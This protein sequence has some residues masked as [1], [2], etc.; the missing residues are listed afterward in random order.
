MQCRPS[1]RRGSGGSMYTRKTHATR[2]APSRGRAHDQPTTREGWV[3][4]GGV[5][6]GLVLLWKS[7]NADGGKEPWFKANAGSNKEP[8][9]GQPYQTRA[10]SDVAKCM[11]CGTEGRTGTL[12]SRNPPAGDGRIG[13]LRGGPRHLGAGYAH[14]AVSPS[15]SARAIFR[16]QEHD[17]LSESRMRNPHVRFDERG[18]ETGLWHDY[19]GTV[20]RRGRQQIGQTCRCRATSRLYREPPDR[21][22]A[23]T[24]TRLSGCSEEVL[25]MQGSGP[26]A[27]PCSAHLD[28]PNFGSACI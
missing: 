10:V 15:S 7:G 20:R 25:E 4:R 22:R 8:R 11:P 28:C 6:E 24:L 12:I 3:G 21:R 9:L 27:Q 17:V 1:P 26:S 2:E 13:W 5:A 18:V 23:Q 19:L 14:L 16:G